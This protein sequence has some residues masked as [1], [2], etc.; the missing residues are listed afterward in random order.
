MADGLPGIQK[1]EIAQ[2]CDEVDSYSRQLTNLGD[3]GKGNG[4]QAMEVARRLSHKLHELKEKINQ[5]VV[6]RVVEDFIDIV[7]PLKLFSEAVL[8]PEGT[9]NR[10]QN[11]SDKAANLQQFSS[12][13][14]KTAK[15]VA[16]GKLK[17]F[18]PE[19]K[20]YTI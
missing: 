14:V 9:P 18:D 8:V 4:P 5:A 11:F 10:D 7:T 12:R 20:L 2:L 17:D 6:N 1:A 13:A 3:Q 15:M 19:P 16:A